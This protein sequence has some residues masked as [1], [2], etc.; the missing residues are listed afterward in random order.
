MAFTF[1]Y[2]I[3]F[4]SVNAK[5]SDHRLVFYS[6]SQRKPRP[7][8]GV[9][10]WNWVGNSV[11]TFCL[12]VSSAL[13]HPHRRPHGEMGEVTGAQVIAEALRAQVRYE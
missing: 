12:A 6:Q 11:Y 7:I 5:V 10:Y 1:I 4:A 9:V 13:F 8:R 3:V 2:C